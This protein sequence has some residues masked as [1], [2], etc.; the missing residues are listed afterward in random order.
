LLD[1]RDAQGTVKLKF[2]YGMVVIDLFFLRPDGAGYADYCTVM[3]RSLLR[4]TH[5]PVAI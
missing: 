1:Q 2:S 3:K 5:P 4:S